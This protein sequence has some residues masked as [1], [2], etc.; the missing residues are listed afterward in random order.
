MVSGYQA[1]VRALWRGKCD[2]YILET[3]VN[4]G[5]GRDEPK[6]V[7]IY[8]K[9]PCRISFSSVSSTTEQDGAPLI[10]QTVKL[11]IDNSVEIPAGSKV[12]VTQNGKTGDYQRSGKPAVYSEHQEI[13]LVPFER[14]A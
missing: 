3:A 8:E 10:Q 11:F 5:N 9:Q 12:V 13:V 4:P 2:V 6:E 14:W 1:A 7:P